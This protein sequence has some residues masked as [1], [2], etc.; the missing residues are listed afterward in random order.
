MPASPRARA[1]PP[2]ARISTRRR[3]AAATWSA[4][5]PIAERAGLDVGGVRLDVVGQLLTDSERRHAVGVERE[6]VGP[7][8]LAHRELLQAERLL[9]RRHDA[10]HHLAQ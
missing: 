4:I 1:R 6:V 3:P 8:G 9:E 10:V 2:A 7:A 5:A